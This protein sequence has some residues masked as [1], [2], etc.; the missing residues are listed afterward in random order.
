MIA[1]GLSGWYL[2]SLRQLNLSHPRFL[3]AN[4]NKSV[5]R[6]LLADAL[7]YRNRNPAI[8]A[9]LQTTSVINP[10][11]ATNVSPRTTSPK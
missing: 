8:D 1:L 4:H 3:A 5:T 9:V 10:A 11:L 6:A 7:E 2:I